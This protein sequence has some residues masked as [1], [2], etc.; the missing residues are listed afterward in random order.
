MKESAALAKERGNMGCIWIEIGKAMNTLHWIHV[1][2]QEVSGGGINNSSASSSTSTKNSAS[3]PGYSRLDA[4]WGPPRLSGLNTGSGHVD[5]TH[6]TMAA[7]AK[8]VEKAVLMLEGMLEKSK[9]CRD[10]MGIM[11]GWLNLG[12]EEGGGGGGKGHLSPFMLYFYLSHHY[13]SPL[14]FS[15]WIY[16][17]NAA[18]HGTSLSIANRPQCEQCI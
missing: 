17:I 14:L 9:Q 3:V 10:W 6:A 11:Y 2:E 13:P 7:G 16:S 4:T 12:K 1:A 15:R 5:E 8:F 18:V